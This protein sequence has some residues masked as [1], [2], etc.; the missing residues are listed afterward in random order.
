MADAMLEAYALKIIQERTVH[1]EESDEDNS[2]EIVSEISS[3]KEGLT[4]HDQES[5][6]DS[7]H[8]SVS[9]ASSSEGDALSHRLEQPRTTCRYFD[10]FPQ[11]V[12]KKQ[13]LNSDYFYQEHLKSCHFSLCEPLA[14]PRDDTLPD[15]P[16]L[17]AEAPICSVTPHLRPV[18]LRDKLFS[19]RHIR[20]V[21]LLSPGHSNKCQRYNL[22]PQAR[23][24]RCEVY[25]ASLDDVSSDGRPLF[26]ALSY[27][28]GSPTLTQ[29]IWC[30]EEYIPTT[31]NLFE[32]LLHVRDQEHPRVLWVDGLCINQDDTDERNHQVGLL[33]QIYS[34]AHVIAWL[35]TGNG[36][37]FKPLTDYLSF[38]ARLWTSVVRSE[39][40]ASLGGHSRILIAIAKYEKCRRASK[41]PHR[42]LFPNMDRIINAA[43]FTRVWVV[44]EMFLGKTVVCQ[45]GRQVFSVAVLTA[46]LQSWNHHRG[47]RT[48]VEDITFRYLEPS[49]S[50]NWEPLQML[51]RAQD[52]SIVEGFGRRQC[53]DPRDHI[54]GLSALFE[55]PTA[56]PIDYSLSVAEVFCNFTVHCLGTLNDWSVFDSY[57]TIMHNNSEL[58]PWL[59]NWTRRDLDIARTTGLPSWCP[60]WARGDLEVGRNMLG[61]ETRWHAS[62]DS[63]L[64]LERPAPF[65][66]TLKGHAISR[67]TWCSRNAVVYQQSSAE[68]IIEAV[69]YLRSCPQYSPLPTRPQDLD[70]TRP[71]SS[72]LRCLSWIPDKDSWVTGEELHGELQ[73]L[74][75]TLI[76]ESEL[77]DRMQELLGPIYL[78]TVVPELYSPANFK[79]SAR[80]PKDN[81]EALGDMMEARISSASDGCRLFL[82]D[83]GMLGT[84]LPG[85]VAG[86]IVCVLFGSD[87]PYVLRPTGTEEQYLL[88]G[89]CYVKELMGGEAMLM[90]L[91]E[92]KFTLV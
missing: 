49:L 85:M 22:R 16:P 3:T 52:L 11:I 77:E 71:I 76:V 55:Q 75:Q 31:D 87:V 80:I 9:Q 27:V 68:L 79:I 15:E 50:G 84:G 43:Y 33:H 86:D 82:T 56:Y 18:K 38:T 42:S 24:L 28:C 30:G 81:F 63:I 57:R 46:S 58:P 92:Q 83:G 69:E 34:Q 7:T 1:D 39:E 40:A 67:V 54:Y 32:A 12:P 6:N 23:Y 47:S 26:A 8:T 53:F 70:L 45:L 60:Y 51:T 91:Q 2:D 72:V 35:G 59:L 62:G 25:Q 64:F 78:A 65:M 90:G 19:P 66:I 44:Q 37:D 89:E 41:H 74:T 14:A 10:N 61:S 73:D 88:I 29:R 20:L 36:K 5:D 21:K 48:S 17:R 4:H 13:V